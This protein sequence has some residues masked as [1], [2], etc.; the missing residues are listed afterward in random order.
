[1]GVRQGIR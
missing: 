1:M